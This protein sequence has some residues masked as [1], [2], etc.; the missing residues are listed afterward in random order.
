MKLYFAFVSVE[1]AFDRVPVPEEA[2]RWDLRKIGEEE[3]LVKAVMAVHEVAQA[4]RTSGDSKAFSVMVGL[5][6]GSVL[7]ILLVVSTKLL[8]K[9]YEA[10]LG[11]SCMQTT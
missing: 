1:Q 5:C 3:W 2:S 4:V 7:S 10:C 6:L 8:L 11:S 9:N